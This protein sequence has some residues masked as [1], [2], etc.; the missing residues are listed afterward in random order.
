ML[1]E[2]WIVPVLRVNNRSV[3]QEFLEKTIGLKTQLEDGPF[4]EFGGQ[5]TKAVRLVLQESPSMR[6]RAVKGPKKLKKLVIKVQKPSEIEGLLARG[7]QFTKL[8][9]GAVGYGFEAV[10]PEG[11]TFLVHGE[12]S[13]A[14]LVEILPPVAFEA[15]EDFQGLTESVV[16]EIVI[17]TPQVAVSQA[18]Y[19]NILPDQ[20]IVSFEA[21]EG[22]DLLTAAEEV[23]DLDSL[24]F[25]V[26]GDFDWTGLEEKLPAGYFK[27]KKEQF[28]QTVDPSG[29]ELWFEK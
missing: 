5:G 10:S 2:E 21:A 26:A 24:R 13:Q 4:A 29:I 7:S 11:D 28:I 25:A 12:A 15:A 27:D 16:E 18:F 9:K 22:A 19:Q 17:R 8:Y 23:W 14:D 6:T 1:R 3:N 20:V